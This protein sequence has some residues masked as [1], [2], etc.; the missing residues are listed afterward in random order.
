MDTPFLIE[1]RIRGDISD[2]CKKLI[3]D[4]YRKF[5]VSGMVR[6][7]PVPHFTLFGPFSC[8]SIKDVMHAIKTTGKDY[9][10]LEYQVKGFDYFELKKKFLFITTSSRK[11]VIYLKINPSDEL[12]E[13]RYALAQ[14]LLKITNSVNHDNDSKEK[15]HFHATLA[16]KDIDRKFDDIWNYLKRYDITKY[17][18][19]YRVTLLKKGKIVC[20]YDF[21]EGKILRRSQV[22]GRFRRR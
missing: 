20:E 10:K 7:R 14:R 19:S 11:N 1:I 15:F 2:L 3:F 16:M 4:I 22:L 21:A 17:G 9:S 12:V 18:T 6:K 13:F 8:R 5:R